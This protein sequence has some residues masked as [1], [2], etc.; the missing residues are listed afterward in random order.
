MKRTQIGLKD[1]QL[2]NEFIELALSREEAETLYQLL[3]KIS[4]EWTQSVQ[5]IRAR[6]DTAV[7]K[8]NE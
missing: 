8:A 5:R 6:L 1:R 2:A 4:V 7:A 3:D